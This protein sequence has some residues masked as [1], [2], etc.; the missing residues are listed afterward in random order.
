[1]ADLN[2]LIAQIIALHDSGGNPSQMMNAIMNKNPN[3]NQLGTQLNN[4]SQGMSKS[5][6]YLQL[7]RQN[8]LSEQ[9]IQGLSRILGGKK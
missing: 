5:E 3:I 7:A 1:M 2:A 4:M 9:N 8:G 6:F